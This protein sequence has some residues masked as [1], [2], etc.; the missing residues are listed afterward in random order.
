M[1]GRRGGRKDRWEEGEEGGRREQFTMF[2]T[3]LQ[4]EV[5]VY[6]W[7]E[8]FDSLGVPRKGGSF[9]PVVAAHLKSSRRR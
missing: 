6:L 7:L 8:Y 4:G 5:T 3:K 2:T 1:G 9:F